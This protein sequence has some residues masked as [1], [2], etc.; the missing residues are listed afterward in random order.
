MNGVRK[1]GRSSTF[2]ILHLFTL[3]LGKKITAEFRTIQVKER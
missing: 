1:G 3:L 2:V